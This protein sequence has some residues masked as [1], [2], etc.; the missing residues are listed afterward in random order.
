MKRKQKIECGKEDNNRNDT[1]LGT[2]N[3]LPDLLNT[4]VVL[5]KL[6]TI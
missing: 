2:H 3:L 5:R 1:T 4:N 6:E